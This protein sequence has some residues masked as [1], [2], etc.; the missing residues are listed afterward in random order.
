M[1]DLTVDHDSGIVRIT[2]AGRWSSAEVDACFGKLLHIMTTLRQQGR[3]V[4]ILSDVID[5]EIQ[6][7][8]IEAHINAQSTG[9]YQPGDRVALVVKS[10]FFK[11]HVREVASSRDVALFCSHAAAE[12]WLLAHDQPVSA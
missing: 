3:P 5:A 10:S 6:N 2:G 8:D 11:A 12:T 4:R 9:I 1:I 7:A